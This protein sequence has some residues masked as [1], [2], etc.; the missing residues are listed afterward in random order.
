[1][2]SSR[3]VG[4]LLLV[5]SCVLLA[6]V[7]TRTAWGESDPAPTKK[8]VTAACNRTQFRV[9]LDVGHTAEFPGATSARGVPEYEFN[10]QLARLIQRHLRDAGFER[11]ILLIT[12]GE[13]LKG[14]A[15]R[16]ARANGAKADLLLSIH[17]DSVPE[18]FLKIWDFD[19]RHNRFSDQ[20]KGHSIFIS[21]DNPDRSGSLQFGRLLG[22]QLKARDLRYAPHYTEAFMGRRRRELVDAETGVYRYD[23]LVVLR[24]TRMPA[25]LLEAG[26]IVNRDEE[27]L[28]GSP[29]HQALIGAAVTDAVVE[30]CAARAPRRPA[31]IAR[32]RPAPAAATQPS[33]AKNP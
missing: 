9:V 11:T 25:V 12:G 15:K 13:A 8:A 5:V 16:V 27:L 20:F 4:T 3:R 30:F 32:R 7:F 18:A 28:M 14:L 29:E 31:Q 26:S 23:Q 22:R 10:L 6:Q 21:N 17:H 24:A 33:D 19:G 2:A 1:M